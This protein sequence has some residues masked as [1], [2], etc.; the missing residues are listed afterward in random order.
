[1][2]LVI[3]EVGHLLDR[4]E[5]HPKEL[6]SLFGWTA[7]LL[8]VRQEP[9]AQQES[10]PRTAPPDR[11]RPRQDRPLPDRPLPAAGKQ[12]KKLPAPPATILWSGA[13]VTLSRGRV[14]A[15]HKSQ[16]AE[17]DPKRLPAEIVDRLR[18]APGNELRA[19]VVVVKISGTDYR[20][21]RFE[22]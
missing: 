7:R 10:E 18:A 12:G 2:R 1:V 14:V 11:Q 13:K 4:E 3:R 8:L 17:A 16:R 22:D 9:R 6:K 20:L 15:F 19:D 5:W 21:E